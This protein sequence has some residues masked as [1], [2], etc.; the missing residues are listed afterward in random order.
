MAHS[1]S[2]WPNSNP[3]CMLCLIQLE[4]SDVN[5]ATYILIWFLD[6]CVTLS[7]ALINLHKLYNTRHHE[8]SHQTHHLQHHYNYM[9]LYGRVVTQQS[10]ILKA[11]TRPSFINL[12]SCLIMIKLFY[13]IMCRVLQFTV[14][15]FKNGCAELFEMQTD[16]KCPS[17]HSLFACFSDAVVTW[18]CDVIAVSYLLDMNVLLLF[19]ISTA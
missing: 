13:I 11:I 17:I 6:D 10:W 8:P 15:S 1:W 12:A 18:P 5:N 2:M 9:N 14:W 19:S 4:W 3:N 16:K 7:F